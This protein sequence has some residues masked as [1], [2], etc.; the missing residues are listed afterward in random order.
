MIQKINIVLEIDKTNEYSFRISSNDD[1]DQENLKKFRQVNCKNLIGAF[2]QCFKC[3]EKIEIGVL[4]SKV[5]GES[6]ESIFIEEPD[7]FMTS[8]NLDVKDISFEATQS[9]IEDEWQQF[10]SE[11]NESINK[12]GSDETTILPKYPLRSKIE[13]LDCETEKEIHNEKH[14]PLLNEYTDKFLKTSD[15]I[16]ILKFRCD[17]CDKTFTLKESLRRHLIR[18]HFHYLA[19][20]ICSECNPQKFFAKRT[21]Y[22][23]HQKIV[24]SREEKQKCPQ[25][26]KL[27]KTKSLKQHLNSVHD[28]KENIIEKRY[29]C[30][31]C[32]KIFS[33]MKTLNKHHKSHLSSSERPYKCKICG[34]GFNQ[35]YTLK[36][37]ETV[38]SGVKPYNC[39]QCG[40][41]FAH[42][43]TFRD[44]ARTHTGDGFTCDVCKKIIYDS[45]NFRR[46]LKMHEK[47]LGTKLT[48][49]IHKGRIKELET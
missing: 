23:E 25:C 39:E 49:I 46:H 29:N 37:H 3:S 48:T 24:H 16:S 35:Q 12:Y 5:Q 18:F 13:K 22:Y 27:F 38:H 33:S 30:E 40:K 20:N 32:G 19:T 1:F 21:Q 9:P 10:F 43:Q 44:H 2:D 31:F 41:K 6:F 14:S 45:K 36:S 17:H 4:L 8:D 47:K 42:K 11:E 7:N 28:P 26:E 34:K 15:S